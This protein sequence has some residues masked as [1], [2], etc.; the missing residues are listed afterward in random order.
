MCLGFRVVYIGC[1][2][3]FLPLRRFWLA[4]MGCLEIP[5]TWGK[6]VGVLIK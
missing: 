5:E 1:A 2:F 6:E 4:C 3:S